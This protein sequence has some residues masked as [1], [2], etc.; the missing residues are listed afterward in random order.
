[1]NFGDWE[2]F[3]MVIMAMRDSELNAEEEDF[4]TRN[5]RFGPLALD[6][7]I[8]GG[9]LHLGDPPDDIPTT[10][11]LSSLPSNASS[12]ASPRRHTMESPTITEI[13]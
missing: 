11:P 10:S 8:S 4:I 7:G 6:G 3:K 13:S 2:L 1:M 12:S 9:S 5:V